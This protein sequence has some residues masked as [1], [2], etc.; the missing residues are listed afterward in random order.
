MFD[1]KTPAGAGRARNKHYAPSVPDKQGVKVGS[2]ALPGNYRIVGRHVF[3]VEKCHA[4]RNRG[5]S[6]A[7]ITCDGLF[8]AQV[9]VCQLKKK[10]K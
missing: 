7:Q 5:V 4:I 2:K 9:A 8:E 6:S 10:K 3:A 1:L